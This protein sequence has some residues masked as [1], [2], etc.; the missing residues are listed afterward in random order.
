MF[1]RGGDDSKNELISSSANPEIE[2]IFNPNR[3]A[4]SRRGKIEGGGVSNAAF[5][6]FESEKKNKICWAFYNQNKNIGP[7]KQPIWG[8]L[9]LV[10]SNFAYGENN[11]VQDYRAILKL[12]Q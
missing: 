1:F 4:E 5:D 3:N 8:H 10:D 9:F 11:M 7:S 6:F 2:L 12:S